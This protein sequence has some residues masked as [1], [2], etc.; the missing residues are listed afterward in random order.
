MI[1]FDREPLERSSS[2]SPAL[3]LA[4]SKFAEALLYANF[5]ILAKP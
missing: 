4:A 3:A 2:S 5:Y 1:A